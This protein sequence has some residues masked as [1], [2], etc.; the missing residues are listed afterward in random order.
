MKKIFVL[1]TNVIIHNPNS[2]FAFKDSDVV[3]PITVLEEIDKFKKGL[4]DKS[5]NSREFGRILDRLREKSGADFRNGVSLRSGG[6][7]Y[8]GLSSKIK[9][10]LENLL[11]ENKNDNLIICT[12]LHFCDT[13][14]QDKVVLVSKD[15][16]VRIKANALGLDA[17]NFKN[18][19]VKF[20]EIY[21]GLREIK[22]DK[23]RFDNAL[24]S[25]FF[26]P[27]KAEKKTIFPNEFAIIR[28]EKSEK[29]FRYSA[30][31]QMLEFLQR[32]FERIF[33]VKPRNSEQQMAI[34]FSVSKNSWRLR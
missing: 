9:E 32:T 20:E 26:E 8:V 15:V 27:T 5:R 18:D 14:P 10:R 19:Q 24:Q 3:I 12:A 7:L 23:K 6:M 1:D 16:N 25:K 2:I 21:T 4:D 33:G 11:L 30:D 22:L 17:Q 28:N 13:H 34:R 31:H 29:I